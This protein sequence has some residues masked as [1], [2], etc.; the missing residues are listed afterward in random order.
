MNRE[1]NYSCICPPGAT[2]RNCGED[3]NECQ[4]TPCLN[5]GTC[6]N[7]IG[8]YTCTCAPRFIGLTCNTSLPELPEPGT[9][10]AGIATGVG[11]GVLLL[12]VAI[13]VIIVLIVVKVMRYKRRHESYSPAKVEKG[14]FSHLPEEE[15]KERL[16]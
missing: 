5:G 9:N 3:I 2:G 15:V 14:S 16:I 8:S 13:T 10:L 7:T 6:T 1:G 4:M 12:L 11:V